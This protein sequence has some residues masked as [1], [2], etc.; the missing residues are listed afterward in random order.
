M[1]NRKDVFATIKDVMV[2]V[3]FYFAF[4]TGAFA[5]R[6]I[7]SASMEPT[8]EVGDRL[9]VSKFA[10]GYNRY[11]LP[12]YPEFVSETRLFSDTPKQGDVA[13]FTQPHRSADEII[14]RVI[15][16]PGDTIKLTNG[17]LFINGELVKRTFIRNVNYTTY[18]GF[19]RRV[20]EYEETLPSGVKHRIYEESDNGRADNTGLYSVPEG[21]YFMMGD[22]RDDSGDSRYLN[23]MGYVKHTNLI[24]R[25][26]VTTFSLYDCDQGKDVSCPLGV[27][28]GRF[29]NNLN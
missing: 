27:P 17:R 21:H 18:R 5:A 24:G 20:K 6:H 25:A 10:Y 12:L 1:K 7:P 13:V 8:L 15:G 11:S 3:F 19:E 14:K 26:E 22:N 4:T 2:T 16:L 28:V 23:S 29:F 9:F